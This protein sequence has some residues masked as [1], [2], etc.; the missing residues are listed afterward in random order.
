MIFEL[1]C[2]NTC[3]WNNLNKDRITNYG[4][5]WEEDGKTY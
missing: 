5:S 1:Q 4:V 3:E 2:I